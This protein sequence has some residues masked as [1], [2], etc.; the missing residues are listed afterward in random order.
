MENKVF[1]DV[2]RKLSKRPLVFFSV[3]CDGFSFSSITQ[4]QHNTTQHNS[5]QS[6]TE[7]NNNKSKLADTK[8]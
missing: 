6:K 2:S 5:K 4:N 1:C 7:Q 3:W 8:S